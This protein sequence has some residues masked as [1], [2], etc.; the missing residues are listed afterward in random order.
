[1]RFLQTV[2]PEMADRDFGRNPARKAAHLQSLPML[3]RANVRKL[4]GYLRRMR[5]FLKV[6]D[7]LAG[8][9][10]FEP[11]LTESES[12]GLPLTY[13]PSGSGARRRQ[14]LYSYP[15]P[16]L[17]HRPPEPTHGHASARPCSGRGRPA[18]GRA[19]GAVAGAA[20]PS[21]A[22][23]G[24]G[25]AAASLGLVRLGPGGSLAP[26]TGSEVPCAP[27][28]PW[29]RTWPMRGTG[30]WREQTSRRAQGARGRP[31]ETGQ[32]PASAARRVGGGSRPRQPIRRLPADWGRRGCGRRSR[33][34][35]PAW[36]I[37]ATGRRCRSQ[38]G[39]VA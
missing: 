20:A 3:R 14:L 31:R 21:L 11:G 32:A 25:I 30:I 2:S 28:W 24:S 4:P 34:P 22:R 37:G 15:A 5:K 13:S 7:W 38:G 33:R 17:Q 36:Q 10:G 29:F 39:P 1:M 27:T 18:A 12:V 16:P 35:P 23:R 26:T 19:G 8:E 6:Q 9:P